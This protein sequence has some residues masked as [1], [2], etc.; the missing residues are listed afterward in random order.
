VHE[1]GTVREVHDVASAVAAGIGFVPE[2]RR[3]QGLVMQASVAEN[4]GLARPPGSVRAGWLRRSRL[5]AA[6]RRAVAELGIR[7]RSVAD[8]VRALSGGN[9]Q[10]VLLARWLRPDVRLLLLDEPTRGVDVVAKAEIHRHLHALAARGVGL[11][12][13]SSEIEELTALCD[14]LYVLRAGAVAGELGREQ[15][16]PTAIL[17]L[18][19]GAA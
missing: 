11:L 7:A 1:D 3:H 18:A 4:V 6:A 10:K 5:E 17:R 9:Q 14:R 16:D 19:T 8:P 13:A 12:V 2:D 15:A